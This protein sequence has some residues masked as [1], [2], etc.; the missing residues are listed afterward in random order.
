MVFD[1]PD[2]IELYRLAS[3]KARIRLE[4][5]GLRS[6]AGRSTRALIA[7]ELGLTPRTKPEEFLAKLQ[8]RI[9]AI[10]KKILRDRMVVEPRGTDWMVMSCDRSSLVMQNLDRVDCDAYF[11]FFYKAGVQGDA[12]PK[13]ECNSQA[14]AM[15]KAEAWVTEIRE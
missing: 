9:D 5:Q 3:L 4:A 10:K 15:D 7:Q 1:T 12:A 8:E 2:G 14:E 6:S 13:I 11:V